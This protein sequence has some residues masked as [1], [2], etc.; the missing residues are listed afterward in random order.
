MRT[1]NFVDVDGLE[2]D[3]YEL[4][5]D[6]AC[7]EQGLLITDGPDAVEVI[8]EAFPQGGYS[9]GMAYELRDLILK[10]NAEHNLTPT[11]L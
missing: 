8:A 2:G 7:P 6:Q 5:C 3:A 1:G 11:I 10:F 4:A 9:M